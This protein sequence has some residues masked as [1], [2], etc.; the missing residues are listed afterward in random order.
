VVS[1]C[2]TAC[3]GQDEEIVNRSLLAACGFRFSALG[4]RKKARVQSVNQNPFVL[5]SPVH[6]RAIFDTPVALLRNPFC[7]RTKVT[8]L[9]IDVSSFGSFLFVMDDALFPCSQSSIL[10]SF[11]TADVSI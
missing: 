7:Q 8:S 10:Y 3:H 9:T 5:P 4:G 1:S 6:R 2:G 11:E